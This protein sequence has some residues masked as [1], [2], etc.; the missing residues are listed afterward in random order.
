[1]LTEKRYDHL[2]AAALM[3]GATNKEAAI[4]AG[5]SESTVYRRLRSP[6]FQDYIDRNC[7]KIMVNAMRRLSIGVPSAAQT[8]VELL[9]DESPTIRRLAAKDIMELGFRFGKEHIEVARNLDLSKRV[10][11]LLAEKR[12]E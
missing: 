11:Q 4:A 3:D 5:V 2:L 1:M 7:H 10:D 6:E 8:L 9:K 12:H